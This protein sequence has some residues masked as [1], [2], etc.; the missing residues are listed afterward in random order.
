M[1]Q[2]TNR[3]EN[4]MINAMT[5]Y[6]EP[7]LRETRSTHPARRWWVGALVMLAT[8][9]NFPLLLLAACLDA[10]MND[11]K[12]PTNKKLRVLYKACVFVQE[13]LCFPLVVCLTVVRFVVRENHG[14]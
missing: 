10:V 7:I 4:G 3:K 2:H 13:A 1:A 14:I 8:A 12:I 5:A 9:G 11:M 6:Y